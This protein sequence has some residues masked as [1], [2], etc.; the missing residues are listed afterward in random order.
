MDSMRKK[1][2]AIISN[3]WL[4]KDISLSFLSVDII[5]KI[6]TIITNILF[7]VQNSESRINGQS[8]VKQRFKSIVTDK[9]IPEKILCLVL[10]TKN[11]KESNR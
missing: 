3:R 7:T 5:Q 2:V 8:L 11:Q 1:C 9:D 10:I 6:K 4:M